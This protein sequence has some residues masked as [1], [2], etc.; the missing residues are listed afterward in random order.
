MLNRDSNPD[1]GQFLLFTNASRPN[2]G[3]SHSPV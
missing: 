2:L 3:S 1:S